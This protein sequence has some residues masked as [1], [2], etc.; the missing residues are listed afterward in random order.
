MRSGDSTA[1]G[2]L[3]SRF[4]YQPIMFALDGTPKDLPRWGPGYKK[5]LREYFTHSSGL[6][7][8]STCLAMESNSISLDPEVKD[9]WGLPAMRVTFQNHPD[10][11]KTMRFLEEK[12]RAI[13]D[14]AGARKIWSDPT[15]VTE[16]DYSRH[17]MG[18]CRMGARSAEVGG[19]RREPYARCAEPVAGGRVEPGDVGPATADRDDPGVGLS[20]GGADRCG[21]AAGD[22]FLLGWAYWAS[23]WISMPLTQAIA[24]HRH[25]GQHDLS[26][27]VGAD[28]EED[29][30]ER[31][32]FAAGLLE[33]VEV[34]E[35]RD[36]V[37]INVEATA[38]HTSG[39]A[40]ATSVVPFAELERQPVLAVGDRQRV[41]E[42]PPAL[43]A[44]ERRVLDAGAALAGGIGGA[45]EGVATEEVKSRPST[46]GRRSPA[47]KPS[48]RHGCGWGA[49]GL[50]L[51]GSTSMALSIGDPRMV[52]KARCRNPSAAGV[53][54]P[55]TRSSAVFA[56]AASA[57][58]SKAFRIGWP[59]ASTRNTR[60]PSAAG[61]GTDQ[62]RES[63][64]GKVQVELVGAFRERD[65][66]SELADAEVAV[67]VG[68]EGPEDA[69]G[70]TE[71]GRSA[72]EAAI[73]S[74]TCDHFGRRRAGW[75]R[76]SIELRHWAAAERGRRPGAHWVR[77]RGQWSCRPD[78]A[79]GRRRLPAPAEPG[80][81]R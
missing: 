32:S 5:V 74:P 15:E 49:S 75:H 4:D 23:W 52:M 50:P 16:V 12:M 39:S 13:L 46:A 30:V 25:E 77:R 27:G 7:S 61:L 63:G 42:M 11:L 6:L 36:A 48:S 57:T 40:V 55:N 3:D 59:L 28:T 73:G 47:R 17:L 38:A 34:L 53:M 29:L 26:L 2:G 51:S 41:G 78:S 18:T 60:W 45:H 66:V 20:H 33:D 79:T 80:Q 81:R 62:V 76:R 65:V 44:V 31:P 58:T 8:H 43:A 19:E 67:D 1:G 21:I 24:F 54:P 71:V 37:G 22:R 9:S 72:G 14:A 68:I 35:Q 69:F 10:D 56:P 64:F 70:G